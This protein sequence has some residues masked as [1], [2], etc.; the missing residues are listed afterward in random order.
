MKQAIKKIPTFDP[1]E[2]QRDW[3]DRKK[4]TSGESIATIMRGLIQEKVNKEKRGK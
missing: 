4:K 3:V 1:S 2:A